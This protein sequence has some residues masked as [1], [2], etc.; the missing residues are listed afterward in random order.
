V[1]VVGGWG[2]GVN[3]CVGAIEESVKGI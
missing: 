3:N 1:V 2:R